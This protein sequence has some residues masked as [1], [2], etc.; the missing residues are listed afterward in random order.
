MSDE[1]IYRFYFFSGIMWS[2]TRP[3]SE[4]PKPGDIVGDGWTVVAVG[5]VLQKSDPPQAQVMV[6]K[7]GIS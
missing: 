4:A 6:E 5:K 2:E 1:I 3:V 7:E